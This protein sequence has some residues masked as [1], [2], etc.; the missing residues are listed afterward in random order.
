MTE[1]EKR[2]F[3]RGKGHMNTSAERIVEHVETNIRRPLP[4]LRG[5][6]KRDVSAV[7]AAGG[8]SLAGHWDE[9]EALVKGGAKL[10]TVNG[11]HNYCV[12][13]GLVPDI[14]VQVDARPFNTRFIQPP[15][16]KTLYCLAS[17]CHP[18]AFD[19]LEGHKV[20]IYHC[21]TGSGE[22]EVLD[23]YYF[24]PASPGHGSRWAFV[25][26]GSTVTLRAI[27]LLRIL[28]FCKLDIFGFDSCLVDGEHHSYEQKENA[29]A[30]M[31]TVVVDGREFTCHSWMAEQA[32]DF[33]GLMKARA[34]NF[35]D[36][37]VHG[38]GLIA[39]LMQAGH[40]KQ[41][42][43]EHGRESDANAA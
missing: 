33:M 19:A 25:E 23:K 6:A 40:D 12:E 34:M 36:I 32:V 7:I 1:P 20:A 30:P 18:S 26:G 43:K 27:S 24:S 8:P 3:E 17:Q 31:E 15:Q 4:Q 22:K 29:I 39:A 37:R 14:H 2:P 38:D 16:E 10:C 42:E 13:R 28:G 5:S 11:T 21:E 9:L 35:E 41:L